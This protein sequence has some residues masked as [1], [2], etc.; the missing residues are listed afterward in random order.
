MESTSRFHSHQDKSMWPWGDSHLIPNGTSKNTSYPLSAVTKRILWEMCWK[1]LEWQ[2]EKHI[3]MR[4]LKKFQ[5]WLWKE[6]ENICTRNLPIQLNISLLMAS[7]CWWNENG[8]HLSRKVHS[9]FECPIS[10]SGW[11]QALRSWILT[12][13]P[14]WRGEPA[15]GY[16]NN[17]QPPRIPAQKFLCVL[18]RQKWLII[19][20]RGAQQDCHKPEVTT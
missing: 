13:H 9:H 18:R 12:E 14:G 16:A 6:R 3:K 15:P 7:P 10:L 11:R 8:Y 5:A 19:K 17:C 4:V 1:S 20:G 2:I